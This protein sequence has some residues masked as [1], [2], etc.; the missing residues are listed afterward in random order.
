[1]ADAFP[2]LQDTDGRIERLNTLQDTDAILLIGLTDFLFLI[3]EKVMLK[4]K[5]IACMIGIFM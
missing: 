1:M 5:Q 3:K 2:A 4:K